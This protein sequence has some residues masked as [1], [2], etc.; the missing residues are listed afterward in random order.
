MSAV[1]P[2]ELHPELTAAQRRQLDAWND[3]AVD[4]PEQRCM[5]ALIAQQVE[6]TPDAEAILGE[7]PMTYGELF[8]AANQLAAALVERGVVPGD[9]VALWLRDPL[10]SVV[11]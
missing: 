6:A 8:A 3:T 4:P 5:R 10:A 7:R 9:V 1:T 11:S 2:P